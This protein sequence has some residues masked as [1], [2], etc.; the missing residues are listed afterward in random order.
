VTFLTVAIATI[1]SWNRTAV[2]LRFPPGI[3]QR[4]AKK[5]SA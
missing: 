3:L 2:A 4:P 1:N 5:A